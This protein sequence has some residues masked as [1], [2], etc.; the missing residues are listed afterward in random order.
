MSVLPPSLAGAVQLT[1]ACSWPPVALTPV[2][3]SGAVGAVG[4]AD[5][6]ELAHHL[7]AE[8]LPQQALV[9]VLGPGLAQGAPGVAVVFDVLQ[10]ADVRDP[11]EY[12]KRRAIHAR[13]DAIKLAH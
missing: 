6:A 9:A 13:F 5:H 12:P 2:G 4:Q 1:V 3:A 11:V 10:D 7:G 8:I